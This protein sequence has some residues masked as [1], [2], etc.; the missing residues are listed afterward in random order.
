PRLAAR[1]GRS[2]PAKA[3]LSRRSVARST[4]EP[5]RVRKVGV[6]SSVAFIFSDHTVTALAG[7]ETLCMLFGPIAVVALFVDLRQHV[8]AIDALVAVYTEHERQRLDRAPALLAIEG[9]AGQKTALQ[10]RE[11][12]AV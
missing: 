10:H 8:F 5:S 1:R 4:A 6:D 11:P 7:R 12:L 9:P 2:S 3:R